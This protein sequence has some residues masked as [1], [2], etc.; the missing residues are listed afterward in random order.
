M[1]TLLRAD[2]NTN[3]PA[4]RMDTAFEAAVRFGYEKIVKMLFKAGAVSSDK[5]YGSMLVD[6]S[7]EGYEEMVRMLLDKGA[8]V[9][10]RA[11][12]NATA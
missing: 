7:A 1:Q 4:G 5:H 8:D 6:A 12:N 9:N 10:A 3:A 11:A 2:A